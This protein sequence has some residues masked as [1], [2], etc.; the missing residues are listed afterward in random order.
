MLKHQRNLGFFGQ[1]DVLRQIDDVL[2][3]GV[4]DTA[5]I[6]L[7]SFVLC[8]LGG[9]GKTEIAIEYTFSRKPQFDAI[10][11]VNADTAQKTA[12]G[13][14]EIAR[15]LG[16]EDSD[17]NNDPVATREI[18]KGWMANPLI[19]T[20]SD[21][22]SPVKEV[23]WLL[24]FDNADDPEILDDYWPV[25]GTGAVLTTS[26]NPIAKDGVYTLTGVDLPPLPSDEASK[27]L[28]K[29]SG[30]EKES[31][32]LTLCEQIVQTLVAFRSQ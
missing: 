11:W 13:L 22:M 27:F 17:S 6:Q 1:K 7:R 30:R 10:F 5:Q 29:L 8:V 12:A 20:T 28:M 16:L 14:S 31:N 18:V 25:T 9:I 21:T 19:Q 3:R 24:I 15:E 23:S 26:R 32:S 2:L 4:D